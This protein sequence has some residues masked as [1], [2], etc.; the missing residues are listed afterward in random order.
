MKF[1]ILTEEFGG[2]TQVAFISA[3]NDVGIDDLLDKVLVQVAVHFYELFL[4]FH[5]IF[6]PHRYI[7]I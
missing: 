7:I 4:F 3:K 5:K 2:E 6:L 1:D